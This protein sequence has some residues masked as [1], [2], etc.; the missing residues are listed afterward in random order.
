MRSLALLALLAFPQDKKDPPPPDPK[1]LFFT[2]LGVKAGETVKVIARGLN[3]DKAESVACAE[4][5][6]ELKIKSKG[7]A[8]LP[9]DAEAAALGDT[10]VEI[11]VKVPKDAGEGPLALVVTTPAGKAP[12]HPLLVVPADKFVR[13]KE[14]NGGFSTAQ[15][16]E[17]G[18][19]VDGAVSAPKDVDV[20][21]IAGKAGERWVF[22][23]LAHRHGSALDPVLTL[24]AEGGRQLAAQDDGASSR[25]PLLRVMLPADGPYYLSLID[26]H[27][28][29]GATHP[30]LLHVTREP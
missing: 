17:A 6:A 27:D 19:W 30:Y 26:A 20:F 8:A 14:Q 9:K 18:Q 21:R 24:H 13:E 15:P 25:D 28:Q 11:E 4:G 2:P 23:V 5:G 29:G 22:E 1:I 7:K 3:L 10:Q 16:I 12:A